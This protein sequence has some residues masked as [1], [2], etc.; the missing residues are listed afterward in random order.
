MQR[1][2]DVVNKLKNER[3]EL[4]QKVINLETF[5]ISED[6][7]RLSHNQK[8][9]LQDQYAAMQTYSKILLERIVLLMNELQVT[10]DYGIETCARS[11]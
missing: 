9:L 10:K 4:R 7:Q 5:L 1:T 3:F 6:F 2:E 11:E 8:S